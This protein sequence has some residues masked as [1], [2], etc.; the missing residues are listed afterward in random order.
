VKGVA[1]REGDSDGQCGA[2]ARG[3]Q[4]RE[5]QRPKQSAAANGHLRFDGREGG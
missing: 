1:G 5:T 2:S 3:G 4:L